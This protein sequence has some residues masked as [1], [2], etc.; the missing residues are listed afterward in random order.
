MPIQQ[1]TFVQDGVAL[2]PSCTSDA[3]SLILGFDGM[4]YGG[5]P[6]VFVPQGG[7]GHPDVLL[8]QEH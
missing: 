7:T 5:G 2:A 6:D 1:T 4:L 3:F 8:H